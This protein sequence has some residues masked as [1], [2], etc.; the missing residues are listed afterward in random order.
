MPWAQNA[1]IIAGNGTAGGGPWLLNG[2]MGISFDSRFN[3]YVG[4]YLNNRTQKYLRGSSVGITL[5]AGFGNG[6][7]EVSYPS[8]VFVDTYDNLYVS[9]AGNSRVLKYTNISLASGSS[10][11]VGQ[12]VAGGSAGSGYHQQLWAY[13]I[14][15]DI[16]GNLYVSECRNNRVMKRVP[17]ASNGSLVAGIGN[18]TSGNGSSHLACPWGIYL[19]SSSSLYIA[20]RDNGR[21]Q[22]W[23]QGSSSGITVAG[24]NGQL[25]SPT[26]VYVDS[27]GTVYALT[28]SGL[29][30]FKAGATWGTLI[31]STYYNGYYFVVSAFGDLYI[32]VFLNK[33][34]QKYALIGAG[35]GELLFFVTASAQKNLYFIV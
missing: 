14:V 5:T 19:D 4:D 25:P 27:Y 2:P 29:H 24:G 8:A 11:I 32:S 6:P 17:R 16:S 3:L 12:V 9:D 15:V 28:S 35:C 22:K 7:S 33:A 10:P 30:Q 23:M 18:G 34:V 26:D 31:V 21:I 1:S 20:D 13:G